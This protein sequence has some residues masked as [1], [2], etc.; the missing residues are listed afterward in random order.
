[1]SQG[2]IL[3]FACIIYGCMNIKLSNFH[4]DARTVRSYATILV[5]KRLKLEAMNKKRITLNLS[6]AIAKDSELLNYK[7]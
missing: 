6:I 2:G 7:I 5:G 1:M 3:E 4:W